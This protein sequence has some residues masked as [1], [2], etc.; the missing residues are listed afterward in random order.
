MSSA[1]NVFV[2]AIHTRSKECLAQKV[3]HLGSLGPILM[4]QLDSFWVALQ[5]EPGTKFFHQ[6]VPELYWAHGCLWII[7]LEREESRRVPLSLV[8]V[9]SPRSEAWPREDRYEKMAKTASIGMWPRMHFLDLQHLYVFWTAGITAG[10]W[11]IWQ[12]I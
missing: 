3:G 10:S 8:F 5:Y 6:A 12:E 1:V 4:I 11:K 2:H 9:W 7:G